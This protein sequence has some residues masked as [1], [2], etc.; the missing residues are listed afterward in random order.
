MSKVN[1]KEQ[2]LPHVISILVFLLVTVA[3]FQPVFFEN[4]S[5][6]QHDINQWRGG[7]QE[8]L[9][10]REANGEE[11]LWTNS[12]F[13]GMPGYLIS[14]KWGIGLIGFVQSVITL[15]LPHPVKVVFA[16]FIGFYIL[17]LSF[18]VRPYLAMAGALAFGLSSFNIIGIGAGH[19]A[20]IAAI[21]YMPMVL[22]GVHLTF[23]RSRLF[24]FALTALA[25]ALEL[26]ANHLQITYYLALIILTYIIAQGVSAFRQKK[27]SEYVKTGMVLLLAAVLSLG[28]FIG[29][30]MS[31]LEYS[32]YSIRGKSEIRKEN[33][34]DEQGLSKSYAFEYS[35]GIF[36]PMTLLIPNILGGSMGTQLDMDSNVANFMRSQGVPEAQVEQQVQSMPTYWGNQS[37]TAP[38]YAGA[39]SVF[40]FVLG[41]MLVERKHLAWII[42]IVVLGIMLSW[43]S[44]F[45][46]FNYF[47][48]DYFPGYN[49]FRSVTF[50]LIMPIMLINLL[51]F[52]ALEKLFKMGLNKSLL[53]K[54]IIAFG[55]TGGLSLILAMIAGVFDYSGAIDSRLPEWLIN[56]LLADRQSLL[57]ADAIRSFIFIVLA[58]G[59]V[60]FS[61]KSKLKFSAAA[62]IIAFLVLIDHWTIDK[63]Y[64]NDNN[65]SRSPQRTYFNPTEADKA[66][67]Q[68]RANSYRVFN[69]LSPWNEARTSFHHKSIGGYHGAKLRR[70][71][72]LIDHGLTGEHSEIITNLQTSGTLPTGMN[73]LNMLNTKYMLA[74]NSAQA[75]ITNYEAYGNT[76][77]VTNL[78]KVNSPDEELNETVTNKD[79]K[80]AV[81]DISKFPVEQASY[82]GSGSVQLTDYA[83]NRLEYSANIAGDAFVV[84]SEIYY[85][86]GWVATIDGIETDIL[87]ANYVLRALNVPDGQHTIVFEFRPRVY[88][89]GNTATTI[90]SI[91]I[92]MIFLGAFAVEFGLIANPIARKS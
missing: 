4:K 55:A 62:L 10:Y 71:Q 37:N 1:F 67:L 11:A 5:L 74:G 85:P 14:T 43:G 33:S 40:L 29:S 16:S 82:S 75:V 58:A 44:S 2:V 83:A 59:V 12:M 31:T 81:V 26:H 25:L 66:I 63:R 3:Y 48:F 9:D 20:R 53:K 60:Y 24:G 64:L 45:S 30:F 17:L 56:P 13:S 61:F 19:N 49:K 28:T 84:F 86:E 70:Y 92:L 27:I 65:F 46:S 36:E 22:A 47:I 32:K 79:Q 76:W 89:Y 39:I 91:L 78:K 18:R 50:A 69:L 23:S 6:S 42:P 7:A 41:L 68:D 38:Y 73:V 8:L 77:L 90:S 88:S 15:G 21:A 35:N 80:T 34:A 52:I 51:G 87:R 54:L 72:D 57:Q